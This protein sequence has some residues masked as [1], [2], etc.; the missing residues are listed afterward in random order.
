MGER[1]WHAR[2]ILHT[3]ER[4]NAAFVRLVA[5]L[6][7]ED[8]PLF[9][10]EAFFEA[11]EG[12]G[13]WFSRNVLPPEASDGVGSAAPAP[14]PAQAAA[15]AGAVGES[16]NPTQFM[17]GFTRELTALQILAMNRGLPGAE[18][19]VHRGGLVPS[20]DGFRWKRPDPPPA[21][22]PRPS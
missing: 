11:R 15:G 2:K 6:G 20:P 1:V 3:E 9:A 21:T 16:F 10:P 5:G 22:A 7:A 19:P 18:R 14:P 13:S 8:E 4:S 12:F 17:H